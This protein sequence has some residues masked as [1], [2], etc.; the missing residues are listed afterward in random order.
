MGVRYTLTRSN[1]AL[2]T[3]LD[4]LTVISAAT[5]ALRL[6]ELTIGG[7]GTASAANELGIFR[8]ATAGTF[9]GYAPN[10]STGVFEYTAD[11]TTDIV[12][13]PA[14]GF[15]NTQTIA[16][17]GGTPPGGLVEGTTYFVRDATTDTFRV[18]ATSGG[19]AI[20][21][22]STGDTRCVVSRIIA[23]SFAS[24]GQMNLTTLSHNLNL[25]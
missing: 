11:A 24:A 14:H 8:V 13:C 17:Y 15:S 5:R 20:D 3:T 10:G 19:A 6:L 21:L 18:A 12:T 23:E 16:F 4:S 22:T 25:A 1:F 9:Y 7:M 2:S